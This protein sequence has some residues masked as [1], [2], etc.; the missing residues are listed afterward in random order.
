MRR[1]GDALFERGHLAARAFLALDPAGLVGA[2]LRQTAVGQFGLARDRLLL[3]AHFGEMGALAGDVVADAGEFGFQIG[4][5]RERGQS[6]LGLRAGGG[7]SR[8]GWR[9]GGSALRRAPTGARRCG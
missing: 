7:R 2:D 9:S 4:G 1:L 6:L 8:R 3:G 5:G